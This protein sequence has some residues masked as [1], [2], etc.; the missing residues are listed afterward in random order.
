MNHE[1]EDKWPL[2]PHDVRTGDLRSDPEVRRN[3]LVCAAMILSPGEYIDQL[4]NRFE[5]WDNFKRCVAIL[6]KFFSPNMKNVKDQ[7]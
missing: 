1:K 3:E 2:L 4:A 7:I 5:Y 6:I